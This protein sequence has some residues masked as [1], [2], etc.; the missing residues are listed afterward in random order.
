MDLLL[1]LLWLRLVV[2]F[3]F[4]DGFSDVTAIERDADA[5]WQVLVE[6]HL[7]VGDIVIETATKGQ[8]QVLNSLTLFSSLF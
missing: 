4:K 2:F 8:V 5:S 3:N 1:L 6:H 7:I